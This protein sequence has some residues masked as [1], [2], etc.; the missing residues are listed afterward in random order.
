[1]TLNDFFVRPVVLQRLGD[2]P[3][4]AFG[5]GSL[6]GW[7]GKASSCERLVAI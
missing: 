5:M 2:E 7:R 6:D 3:L 4:G 1:M